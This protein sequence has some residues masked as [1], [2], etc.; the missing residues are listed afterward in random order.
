MAVSSAGTQVAQVPAGHTITIQ[1]TGAV[2]VSASVGAQLPY[3][4]GIILA[5]AA[6]TGTPGGSLT[7]YPPGD[8]TGQTWYA[9]TKTAAGKVSVLV[10]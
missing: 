5:K 9:I 10:V 7:T 4:D 6:A 3:G 8:T 2:N 1:N